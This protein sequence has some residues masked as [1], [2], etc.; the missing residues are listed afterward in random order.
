MHQKAVLQPRACERDLKIGV[1]ELLNIIGSGCQ[2]VVVRLDHALRKHVQHDLRVFRIVLIPRA[3]PGLSQPGEL[4][5]K[6][7][8]APRS[9]P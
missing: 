5:V 4:Q 7:W 8:I 2:S 6:R 3:V 1:C 9:P